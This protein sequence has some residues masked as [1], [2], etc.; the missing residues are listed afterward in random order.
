MSDD[1]HFQT[2]PHSFFLFAIY[3]PSTRAIPMTSNGDQSIYIPSLLVK[4][5][6][7]I[8]LFLFLSSQCFADDGKNPRE[9][10]QNSDQS[11]SCD[12]L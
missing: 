11:L 12:Q 5:S 6:S 4:T 9:T 1:Q 2:H 10:Y 3:I 7:D 8:S